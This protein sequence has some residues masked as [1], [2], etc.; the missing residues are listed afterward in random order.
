MKKRT[1][2]AIL[3]LCS[4][5]LMPLALVTKASAETAEQILKRGLDY[6][7]ANKY[8]KA[9]PLLRKAANMGNA[10]AEYELGLCYQGGF[11]LKQDL[12]QCFLWYTKSAAGGDTDGEEQLGKCYENGWGVEKNLEK[13]KHW[14]QASAN[15][16]NKESQELL[17]NL[18]GGQSSGQSSEEILNK[19]LD[20]FYANKYS[21]SLPLF[22]QAASMGNA[23]AQYELGLCYQGG[24]GLDQDLTQCFNWYTKSAAGGDPDG[25]EQL[26]K[27]YENGWGV[28]QDLETAKQWYRAS[29]RQG[30]KESQEILKKLGEGQPEAAPQNSPDNSQPSNPPVEKL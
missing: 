21:Q 9:L 27:C 3:V 19:A 4:M 6:F 25:E 24:F 30:S 2:T 18:G 29:A 8:S 7:Y 28:N 14:Y 12:H 17:A 10:K 22:R 11:G 5:I 26:G 13:A 15:Q 16:G 1:A 23:K 20:Y